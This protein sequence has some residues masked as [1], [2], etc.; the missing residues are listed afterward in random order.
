[1]TSYVISEAPVHAVDTSEESW[2][3]QSREALARAIALFDSQAAFVRQLNAALTP[4][5][6]PVTHA[7]VWNW[8]NRDSAITGQYVLAIER[9][10]DRKVARHELRPDL[11]PIE[12]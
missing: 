11:Y 8:L 7:Y 3:L 10:T 12:S 2:L 1:M 9:I 6:K 5:T 4:G